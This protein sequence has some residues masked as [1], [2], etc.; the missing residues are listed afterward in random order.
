MTVR[1]FAIQ[2][3]TDRGVPSP[4]VVRWQVGT[5]RKSKSFAFK[6]PA[7]QYRSRLITAHSQGERFDERTGEP[8]SWH[9]TD[10]SLAE[11]A[12]TWLTENWPTWQPKSRRSTVEGLARLLVGATH[13]KAGVTATVD[14]EVVA[15]AE[16]RAWLTAGRVSKTTENSTQASTVEM[17][18][19][20]AKHGDRLS[21]MTT[22]RCHEI[23]LAVTVKDDGQPM[24]AT[25]TARQRS[26]IVALL[27]AATDAGHIE[28]M[29]WPAVRRFRTKTKQRSKIVDTTALPSIDQ[30]LTL[31]GSLRNTAAQSAGYSVLAAVCFY[32]GTR[33]GEARAID[34]SKLTLPATGWGS[35]LVDQAV[36]DAGGDF[37][38]VD[39]HIHVTKTGNDRVV[40]L[41]PQLVDILS[42]HVG[43]RKS[44]LLVATPR[45][46]PVDH[47]NWARAWARAQRPGGTNWTL[48]DLRHAAA[49][50]MLSA[51]IPIGEV[52]RR[53]G[54]SPEVL[55]SHYAGVLEGDEAA[56]NT[57]L[58]GVF[59]R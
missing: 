54:H 22:T 26:T 34:V 44:G 32:A 38:T 58:E 5:Q 57:K 20:L 25:T 36:K 27:R 23:N 15:R 12:H 28:S 51:G 42:T 17:P 30:T 45:N 6:T 11:Y 59:D 1:V 40:P 33:P 56:S 52:A 7:D 2:D 3:R 47:T 35:L 24:A 31:I 14:A 41:A 18:A 49:T 46:L 19:W 8:N 53:L 50:T 10:I 9:R 48:Y 29:P 13:T 43:D 55:L 16:V 37:G 21:D 4:Y 39:E